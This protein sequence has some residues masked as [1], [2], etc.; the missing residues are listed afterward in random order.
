VP[1]VHICATFQSLEQYK[2]IVCVNIHIYT[3][4]LYVYN[5]RRLDNRSIHHS[6]FYCS[7]LYLMVVVIF[8]DVFTIRLFYYRHDYK[9][10]YESNLTYQWTYVCVCVY[11]CVRENK[12]IIKRKYLQI[13]SCHIIVLNYF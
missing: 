10:F 2:Y 5:R 6:R 12:S 13:M 11:A 8:T 4:I 3:Y 7:R 9:V 1:K